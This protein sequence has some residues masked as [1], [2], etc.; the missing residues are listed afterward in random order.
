LK[1][2]WPVVVDLPESTWPMTAMLMCVFSLPMIKF[3]R[4]AEIDK[5][6]KGLLNT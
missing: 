5:K 3:G 6:I 2:K 1:V 4:E